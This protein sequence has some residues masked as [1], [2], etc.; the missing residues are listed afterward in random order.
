MKY[1]LID[2]KNGTKTIIEGP[3]AKSGKTLLVVTFVLLALKV[4]PN[5]IVYANIDIDHPNCH[6]VKKLTPDDFKEGK[7]YVVVIDEMDTKYSWQKSYWN[8]GLMAFWG[9]GASH[10]NCSILATIQHVY[11]ELDKKLKRKY[12]IKI[13]HLYENSQT[14]LPFKVDVHFTKPIYDERSQNVDIAIGKYNPQEK[15]IERINFIGFVPEVE[16]REEK[17]SKNENKSHTKK[18]LRTAI[19]NVLEYSKD[20]ETGIYNV[21]EASRILGLSRN[22]IYSYVP[23]IVNKK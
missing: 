18:S 17:N 6:K 16:E 1:V 20:R 21:S 22:T 11:T 10:N 9:E 4:K 15:G 2:P 23:E 14:K 3:W 13:D 7:E 8:E 19:F 12:Q 5:L